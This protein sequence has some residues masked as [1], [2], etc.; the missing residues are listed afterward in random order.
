MKDK[1][2]KKEKGIFKGKLLSKP[3][4]KIESISSTKLISPQKGE[5]HALV[6]EGRTGYFND[7]YEKEMKWLG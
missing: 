4:I 5:H 2:D 7:E 3:K 1:K 6:K